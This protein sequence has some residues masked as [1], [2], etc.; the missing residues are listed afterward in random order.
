MPFLFCI[1]PDKHYLPFLFCIAP[2][3]HYLCTMKQADKL[4]AGLLFD[5]R[6]GHGCRNCS[7]YGYVND[8]CYA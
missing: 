2:D 3:K 1:A 6:I 7:C 4:F 8:A 5:L